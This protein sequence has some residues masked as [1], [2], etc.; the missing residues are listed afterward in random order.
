MPEKV[1]PE[2]LFPPLAEL[3]IAAPNFI[4]DESNLAFEGTL[5]VLLSPRLLALLFCFDN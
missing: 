5:E 1:L 2:E 4:E 3:K